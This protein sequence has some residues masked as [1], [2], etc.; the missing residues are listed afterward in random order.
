MTH[1]LGDSGIG[2]VWVS[3]KSMNNKEFV[4]NLKYFVDEL[5][6]VC[7]RKKIQ[8]TIQNINVGDMIEGGKNG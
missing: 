6:R 2:N 4:D 3:L 8:D 1:R 7:P 5:E